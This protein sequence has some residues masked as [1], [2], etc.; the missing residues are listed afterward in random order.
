MLLFYLLI[1]RTFAYCL[2]HQGNVFEY[3][4][5]WK[6]VNKIG[7]TLNDEQALDQRWI[8]HICVRK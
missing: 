7:S 3:R 4:Y 1:N 5:K 2:I 8:I 6:E